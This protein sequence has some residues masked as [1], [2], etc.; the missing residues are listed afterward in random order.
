MKYFLFIILLFAL[1]GCRTTEANYRAAYE[2]AKEA[3]EAK[4]AEDDGLDAETRRMLDRQKQ[5]GVSKQI[6]GADTLAITTLFVKMTDGTPDRVPR[7]S[8]TVHSFSQR[9]NAQAMM[10]RLRENGYPEAYVF[11][12]GTPDYYVATA[13]TDSIP[14]LPALLKAA[15]KAPALGQGFPRVIQSGGY[16]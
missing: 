4:A 14:A 6:V 7:Y 1:S 8:V 10:R 13:G 2:V 9:F 15:A 5:R 11:E 16:R 3:R 12:T